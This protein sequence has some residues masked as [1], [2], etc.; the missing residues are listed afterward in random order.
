MT[1]IQAIDERSRED[2]IKNVQGYN[3]LTPLDRVK[4]KL[5]EKIM[6]VY[7]PDNNTSQ[8]KVVKKLKDIDLTGAD[9]FKEEEV[10]VPAKKKPVAGPP[11][12]LIDDDDFPVPPKKQAPVQV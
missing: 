5:V 6:D 10:P 12:N 7:V 11:V 2:F 1:L 3:K 9:D 8:A 4:G